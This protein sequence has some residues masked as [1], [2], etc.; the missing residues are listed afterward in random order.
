MVVRR[1]RWRGLAS[2]PLEQLD[3]LTDGPADGL[4]AAPGSLGTIV[5][6]PQLVESAKE[7]VFAIDLHIVLGY[8]QNGQSVEVTGIVVGGHFPATGVSSLLLEDG[9]DC[10]DNLGTN[11]TQVFRF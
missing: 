9:E 4:D 3:L 8:L 6:E 5:P 10:H 11:A 7:M 2:F 1:H